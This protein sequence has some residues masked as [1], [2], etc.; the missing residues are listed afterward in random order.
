[1]ASRALGPYSKV[2]ELNNVR[3]ALKQNGIETTLIKVR[4]TP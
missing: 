3:E 4:E 1:M 2:E